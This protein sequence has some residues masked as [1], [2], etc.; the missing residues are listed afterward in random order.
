MRS[1]L[2]AVKGTVAMLMFIMVKKLAIFFLITACYSQ[3]T[4]Y[5]DIDWDEVFA[6]ENLNYCDMDFD[7][8]CEYYPDYYY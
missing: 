8:D 4:I 1:F 5:D 3:P 7:A 6:D 2:L